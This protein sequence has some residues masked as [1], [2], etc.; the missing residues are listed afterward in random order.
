MKWEIAKSSGALLKDQH[1][2]SSSQG[3]TLV[4]NEG[5]E[6]QRGLESYKER[7]GCVALGRELEGQPPMSLW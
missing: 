7:L 1:T 5:T 4:S 3:L 2:K 6:A